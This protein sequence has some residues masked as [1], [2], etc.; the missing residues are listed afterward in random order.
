MSKVQQSMNFMVQ[1]GVCGSFYHIKKT[2]FHTTIH[3]P[4]MTIT[5]EKCET[6]IDE[7]LKE[8]EDLKGLFKG[9]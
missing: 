1:C 9:E 6:C 7:V 2:Y 3:I 4:Q 5:V 8:T